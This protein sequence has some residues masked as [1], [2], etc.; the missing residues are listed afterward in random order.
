MTRTRLVALLTLLCLIDTV[1]PVPILGLI[2]F[3]VVLARPAW[4]TRAV[5]QIYRVNDGGGS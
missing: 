3:H 4:F 2:L 1:I 5:D